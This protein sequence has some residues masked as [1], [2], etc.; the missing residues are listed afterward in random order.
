MYHA[1]F[2]VGHNM[3]MWGGTEESSIDPSVVECFNVLS[4]SWEQPRRLLNVAPPFGYSFMAVAS[5]GENS[6]LFGGTKK[7]E[8]LFNEI[9]E[10]HMPSLK[11]RKLV[12]AADSITNT[13]GLS[14]L[15]SVNQTLIS[16]GGVIDLPHAMPALLKELFVFDL[17]KSE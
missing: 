16:Y 3:F 17:I 9:Y 4:T 12:P 8:E 7:S 6:Y 1:A 2:A 11:C 13:K 14:A 10:I 5:D 15:V